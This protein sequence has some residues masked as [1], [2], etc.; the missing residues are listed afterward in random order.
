[1]AACFACPSGWSSLVAGE[2]RRG[3]ATECEENPSK[4]SELPSWFYGALAAACVCVVGALAA[5]LYCWT[6]RPAALKLKRIQ[7]GEFEELGSGQFG[8]AYKVEQ[9]CLSIK[10]FLPPT[11]QHSETR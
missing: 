9:F 4:D 2:R 5:A 11:T 6:H 1:M 8:V 10:M 7:F 3:G